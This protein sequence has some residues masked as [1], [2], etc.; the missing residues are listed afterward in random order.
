MNFQLLNTNT[1]INS[2]PNNSLHI[3]KKSNRNIYDTSFTQNL[4]E[5]ANYSLKHV[6]NKN[7]V[8]DI[9]RINTIMNNNLTRRK[10]K[11]IRYLGTGIKGNLYLAMD[12]KGQRFICKQILLDTDPNNN[13]EEHKQLDFELNILKYLSNNQTT[14][15][16][17]NPC[18]EHLIHDK[19][20]Y[21]IFPVFNGYSLNHFYKYLSRMTAEDYYKILFFLI[22]SL[23]HALAKIHDTHIAHQNIS[24]NSILVST[25]LNPTEIKVK[26]T[27][28]GLGCGQQVS[29]T[30]ISS[31][32]MMNITDYNIKDDNFFNIPQCRDNIHAPITIN[33]S[34]MSSLKNSDYLKISQKW[35]ILNLGLILIKYILYMEPLNIDLTHGYNNKLIQNIKKI[36]E[37]KYLHNKETQIP[38]SLV[39]ISASDKLKRII[40]EYL[41]IINK[42]ILVPTPERKSAQYVLDKII[43]YEK[44]KDDV[45]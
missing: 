32:H 25:Y 31:S 23:L 13:K 26:F 41:K 16:H 1:I 34:I 6:T 37:N 22:K 30:N 9:A 27:D 17:I 21:T 2:I 44:Y 18:L 10:Y 33:S 14:R 4:Q 3:N 36:I 38:I 7:K 20:V 42:Y 5:N 43:I 28:F 29:N 24:E 45:F 39:S 12:T 40:L 15:E 19:T 8:L 11:I 35:D